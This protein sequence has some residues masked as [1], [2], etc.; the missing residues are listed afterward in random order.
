MYSGEVPHYAKPDGHPGMVAKAKGSQA[1]ERTGGG[2]RIL[3]GP[4]PAGSPT[5]S[6]WILGIAL[7]G[8]K[9]VG[10]PAGFWPKYMAYRDRKALGTNLLNT[11]GYLTLAFWLYM[12]LTHPG[13]RSVSLVPYRWVWYVII[14][15]TILMAEGWFQRFIAVR[16]IS[17]T[18][19]ALVSVL[20]LPV[21][22]A[23]NFFAT[24]VALKQF[25]V[26][27]LTG[28]QAG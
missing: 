26:S 7:Q 2:P 3:P 8:W 12:V 21:G 13:E 9:H 11:L 1:R 17:G 19:Q 28:K 16:L 25:L 23:I 27:K 10:W 24:T 18:M 5:E 15:D 6:R 22:N 14:A 20:R 4:F